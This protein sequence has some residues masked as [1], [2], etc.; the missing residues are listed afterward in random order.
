LQYPAEYWGQVK[1]AVRDALAPICDGQGKEDSKPARIEQIVALGDCAAEEE[2]LKVLQ[3]VYGGMPCIRSLLKGDHVVGAA[4]GA[5]AQARFGMIDGLNGCIPYGWCAETPEADNNC[6]YHV[7][8][9]NSQLI[10]AI[11][12]ASVFRI[13]FRYFEIVILFVLI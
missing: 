10:T 4:R 6:L 3:E 13:R 2:F 7:L 1:N 11:R 5:A 9:R 12:S 8:S